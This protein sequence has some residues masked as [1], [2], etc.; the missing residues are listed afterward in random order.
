MKWRSP[1]FF[2]PILIIFLVLAVG[3]WVAVVLL[4]GSSSD[5]ITIVWR[6]VP[7]SLTQQ[8]Q[9]NI[10][11]ALKSALLASK[12]D[13]FAGNAFTIVDTQRQGDWV[14]FSAN[15]STSPNA[16]PIPTEPLFFVGHLQGTTCTVCKPGTLAFCYQLKQLPDTLLDP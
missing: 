8:D 3:I 1:R 5:N 12:T 11:S 16:P 14:I 6:S 9:Q 15:E 4:H 10:Q 2:L 7:T 13:H